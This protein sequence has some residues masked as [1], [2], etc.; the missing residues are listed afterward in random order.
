M[1]FAGAYV[2][3]TKGGLRWQTPCVITLIELAKR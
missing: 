2:F 3:L 1:S